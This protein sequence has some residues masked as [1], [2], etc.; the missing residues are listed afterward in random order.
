MY[1]KREIYALQIRVYSDIKKI[2]ICPFLNENYNV[3]YST[4]S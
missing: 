3:K 4:F 1:T 2:K